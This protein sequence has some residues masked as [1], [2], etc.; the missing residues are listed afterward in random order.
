M[1]FLLMV[2][3]LS[4]VLLL[5][6]AGVLVLASG[7]GAANTAMMVPL[8]LAIVTVSIAL[9]LSFLRTRNGRS[10]KSEP[11]DSHQQT[12]RKPPTSS[13]HQSVWS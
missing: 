11:R 2:L 13:T 9:Y 8:A 5:L 6:A 1:P 7:V 10:P 3:F 12:P 4:F